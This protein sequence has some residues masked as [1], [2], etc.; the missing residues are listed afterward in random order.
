M[1]C[2]K[3]RTDA[4][5]PWIEPAPAGRVAGLLPS[6]ALERDGFFDSLP[7]LRIP[8]SGERAGMGSPLHRVIRDLSNFDD[9]LLIW[10]GVRLYLSGTVREAPEGYADC[11]RFECK[12]PP[13]CVENILPP[14]KSIEGAARAC[15]QVFC[16]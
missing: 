3:D 16:G 1:G 10:P 2:A 12:L 11:R 13:V 4:G 6:A 7:F 14:G 8:G 15:T 9:A 5:K